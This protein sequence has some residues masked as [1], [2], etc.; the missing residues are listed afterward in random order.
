MLFLVMAPLYPHKVCSFL[1]ISR[2]ESG[3]RVSHRSESRCG[4][5]ASRGW[6]KS[7]DLEALCKEAKQEMLD[8]RQDKLIGFI[9][10]TK[11]Y[12]I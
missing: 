4:E 7:I 1:H 11:C 3:C 2:G 9:L 5:M 6:N 12:I 10:D 8:A